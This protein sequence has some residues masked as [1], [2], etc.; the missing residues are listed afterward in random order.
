[1]E[2]RF[3]FSQKKD[4]WLQENRG[5]SFDDA[6]RLIE[7]GN[8]VDITNTP[9]Q[10][11]H[12]NQM[13]YVLDIGGYCHLVPCDIDEENPNKRILKTIYKSRKMHRMYSTKFTKKAEE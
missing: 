5:V 1:M 4:L 12:P 10:E 13:L 6:V 11:K 8:I 9:D 2:F 7:S 3:E